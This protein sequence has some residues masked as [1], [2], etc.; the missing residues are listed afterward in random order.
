MSDGDIQDLLEPILEAAN[1]LGVHVLIGVLKTDLESVLSSLRSLRR[2]E[3][4]PSVVGFTI[5]PPKGSQLSQ[6]AIRESLQRVL[7]EGVPTA[8]YQLPQVTGN[9][10]S[11]ETVRTLAEQYSNFFLFK[12][13]SGEDRVALAGVYSN[14]FMVRGSEKEGYARWLRGCGGPYDG[15][16][17]SSANVFARELATIM[18]LLDAGQR[19]EADMLSG[20]IQSVVGAAFQMVSDL[21]AG[22]AFTNANKLL[23]HVMAHGE[24]AAHSEPP[25][26]YSGFRLPEA[27]VSQ[28]ISSLK[29]HQL[30]PARGYLES[31]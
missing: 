22:N 20:K 10:M 17:L 5:C 27:L 1:P 21:P 31:D 15:F 8:L 16:L 19:A 4:H 3:S 7:D 18:Q 13:T 23:D 9:E 25:L 26:L 12:D 11:P 2:F 29:V 28:V 6:Q 14:V 24:G 30:M